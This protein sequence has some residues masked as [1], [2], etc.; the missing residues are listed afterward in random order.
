MTAPQWMRRCRS[1]FPCRQSPGNPATLVACG[2]AGPSTSRLFGAERADVGYPNAWLLQP[3]A[4]VHSGRCRHCRPRHRWA[5]VRLR[6]VKY[7]RTVGG[8]TRVAG[9]ARVCLSCV[10]RDIGRGRSGPDANERGR[11]LNASMTNSFAA[12]AECLEYER[13]AAGVQQGPLPRRRRHTSLLLPLFFRSHRSRFPTPPPVILG[14]RWVGLP[15]RTATT[16]LQPQCGRSP[17]RH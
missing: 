10:R 15:D 13:A 9:P 11:L 2:H 16:S 6:G 1:R 12:D 7:S 17:G 5:S 8:G 3:T 4:G 14:L